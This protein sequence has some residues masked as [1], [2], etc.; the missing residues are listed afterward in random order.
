MNAQKIDILVKEFES[1]LED[2]RKN[3]G[4]EPFI[5]IFGEHIHNFLEKIKDENI[6]LG[7]IMSLLQE[8]RA[9]ISSS[10]AIKKTFIRD[11][12]NKKAILV[13]EKFID[14]LDKIIHCDSFRSLFD[15][16]TDRYEE[17]MTLSRIIIRSIKNIV[18]KNG[19]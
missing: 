17:N 4:Y 6:S 5:T 12:E 11:D 18:E 7:D 9:N 14:A 10:I 15:D 16:D 13:A 3:E 2:I 8:L 1:A 19:K